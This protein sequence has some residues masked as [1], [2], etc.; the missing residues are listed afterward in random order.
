VLRSSARLTLPLGLLALL[1]A[2]VSVAHAR[3]RALEVACAQKRSGLLRYVTS[4]A[5]CHR[6]SERVVDFVKDGPLRACIRRNGAVLR[7]RCGRG[8]QVVLPASHRR[9]FC[10]DRRTRLLRNLLGGRSCRAKR[11]FKVIL[12]ERK[13]RP[14]TAEL[15][16]DE[17][18]VAPADSAVTGDQAV[19]H[20]NHPPGAGADSASTD[21]DSAIATVNVLSSDSDLDGDTPLRISAI[22]TTGAIGDVTLSAGTLAYNPAGH[23]DAL[24]EDE[25]ATDTF[26]YRAADPTAAE[27]ALATVTVTVTG[28]D[29]APILAQPDAALAYRSDQAAVAVAPALTAT[30]VDSA[31]LTG[32]T[33]QIGSGY[34]NGKDVLSFADTPAISGS[35]NAATGTLTLTGAD[36]LANYG[37]A[38]RAVTF[39]GDNASGVTNASRSVSVQVTDGT[40]TSGQVFRTIDVAHVNEAPTASADSYTGAVGNTTL[41]VGTA[42]SGPHTSVSGDVLTNDTDPDSPHASLTATVTSPTPSGAKVTMNPDGTFR[43]VPP[44]G[45]SGEDSFQYTLH[46]NDAGDPKTATGTITVIVAG[47]MTW[48]VDAAAAPGGDG[49]SDAPFTTLAALSTGG[50]ADAKDGAGDRIFVYASA[51]SYTAGIVLEANQRV[52]GE[53]QGLTAGATTLVA[54]A[55]SNPVIATSGSPAITLAGGADV[56]RVDASAAGSPAVVGTGVATATI[57]AN[58]TITGAGGGIALDGGAGAVAIQSTITTVGGHSVSVQNRTGGTVSFAGT[59]TDTGTGIEL[60]S[61][62]GASVLFSGR[63]VASTG[64]SSAFSAAGGGTVTAIGAASTLTSTT[65]TTLDVRG[66]TIGASGLKFQSVSANGAPNGIVLSATGSSGGLTVTG[67]ASAN[68]GGT[69]QSTSGHAI[70]LSDTKNV[71]LNSIRVQS[72]HEAG[73]EGANVHGFTLTKSTIT[74]AGAAAL[75]FNGVDGALAVTGNTLSDAY[76][77]GLDVA[78][79]DGIVTSALVFNNAISNT[80]RG[81]AFNLSGTASTVASVTQASITSNTITNLAGP[82]GI[83]IHGGNTSGAGAPAETY[84]EPS[85]SVPGDGAHIID[86]SSNT[87]AGRISASV[88]GRGQGNASIKNNSAQGITTAAA[89]DVTMNVEVDGNTVAGATGVS[90]ATDKTVQADSS[91]L[92]T[93]VVNAQ[94][95]SNEISGSSGPGLS[96]LTGDSNGT[97]RVRLSGNVIGEPGMRIDAG[98]TGSATYN[99]TLCAD[100]GANLAPGILLNK[101]S[102]LAATYRFGLPGLSPEP[103]TAPAVEAYVAANNPATATVGSGDLFTACTLPF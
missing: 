15:V 68:S 42:T 25:T 26:S 28:V 70:S 50:A 18:P 23:F 103:A 14:V 8:V 51:S 77:G 20:V 35:W 29:D 72:P 86:I 76:G 11:E 73:V 46:D 71:S 5:G 81:I 13:R 53:P 37:A 7:G 54:P 47:P 56:Q 41:A 43:Y 17:R 60:R 62:T 74:G 30:D 97:T 63:I 95:L 84:G 59:V 6:R 22:D 83:V 82:D 94:F 65:G 36:T 38:L 93:P 40:L 64:P 44:Q 79:N 87:V 80:G 16:P 92:A 19:T 101:R 96:V 67:T 58:T 9:S 100:I 34:E 66:D 21:E 45:F 69:I 2:T 24:A 4:A 1:C 27:S 75:A 85:G 61:N 57:G 48:Y 55:G 3:P 10:V 52:L 31:T 33:I 98:S 99:P 39:Q 49:R 91:T 89:G 102:Q 32:A 88:T 78:N 12:A 90:L